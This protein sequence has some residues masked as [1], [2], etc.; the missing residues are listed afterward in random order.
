MMSFKERA[1][2]FFKK[3]GE[4]E[5]QLGI[6][7]NNDPIYVSDS[8]DLDLHGHWKPIKFDY[9]E[10]GLLIDITAE[11]FVDLNRTTQK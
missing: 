9:N 2:L 7:I 5:E 10:A 4:L 1:D 3:I 6:S 11:W 8:I